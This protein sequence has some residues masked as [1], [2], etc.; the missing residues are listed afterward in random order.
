[1]DKT[2][3][4]E[5]F[6][7]T[8]NEDW[9]GAKVVLEHL[10]NLERKNPQVH[11]KLGDIYQRLGKSAN[12]IAAYHQSAWLLKNQ[13]FIQKALALYKIILRLD[14]ENNEALKL[15][16]ELM[17]E[18][19]NAKAAKSS[20][21]SIGTQIIKESFED[22]QDVETGMSL[23]L[24]DEGEPE[25]SEQQPLTESQH[26]LELAEEIKQGIEVS[27]AAPVEDFIERT[28]Y[29]EQASG[30]L[31]QPEIQEKVEITLQE[32]QG[33]PEKAGIREDTCIYMN[34]LFSP[35]PKKEAQRL[36]GDIVPQV[37]PAG[38]TI[39]EEGDAGDS[40]YIIKSGHAKVVSH[41]LGREIEL[42]ILSPGD[43]FGE[44]A[45]L[46]GRPRTASV[47]ALDDLMA[48]EIDK[49]LLQEIIETYPETIKQ[50]HDFYQCRV[51]DTLEKVKSKLKK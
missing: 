25:E 40:I 49:F 10:S 47:V 46:T 39:I 3:W 51:Q 37:Y 35:L 5:Y 20:I 14:S 16:K 2:Y 48:I 38:Q 36:I 6:I 45:F 9:S 18:L 28:A 27:H 13:G 34:S 32:T 21:S 41:I 30:T 33:A 50:M 43:V 29:A 31:P 12:A 15:S 4:E 22:K 19:E 17:M 11:L 26:T 8:K 23:G 44:V 1:M 24:G 42:A 7:S